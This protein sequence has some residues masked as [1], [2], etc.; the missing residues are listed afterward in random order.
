[1]IDM[2]GYGLGARYLLDTAVN[3]DDTECVLRGRQAGRRGR[4]HRPPRLRLLAQL[5]GRQEATGVAHRRV[6]EFSTRRAVADR[7]VGGNRPRRG[8]L[9]EH[10]DRRGDIRRSSRDDCATRGAQSECLGL[11]VR[12]CRGAFARGPPRRTAAR[13]ASYQGTTLLMYLPGNENKALAI[14][15]LLLDLGA[16]ATLIGEEGRSAADLAELRGMPAVAT[17]LRSAAESR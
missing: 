12:R 2:G 11:D 1:M 7:S 9:R 16:D 4:R 6:R 5:T 8:E 15:K 3:H 17:V 13:Q 14:A 10:A